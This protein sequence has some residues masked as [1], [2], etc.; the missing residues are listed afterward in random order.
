MSAS[1]IR[2]A[3]SIYTWDLAIGRYDETI[4][5]KGINIKKLAYIRNPY[6]K[7]WF[8]DPFILSENDNIIQLLVE[9]FDSEVNKGRIARIVI[10]K[11]NYTIIECSIIL[12]LETHLSF[13]AIYREG[14][15]IYVHPENSASGKSTIYRYDLEQDRLVDPIVL[16]D[17]P[18]TD[19]VIIQ[20]DNLYIMYST[21]LPHNSGPLLHVYQS[22]SLTHPFCEIK[23]IDYGN[24]T[25]RMAGAILETSRSNI[26][27]AQDCTH[28][29]GEAVLFYDG[30]E[31]VGEIRP[32]A[33][34][35]YAGVH[36]FNKLS[37]TFVIDL[38]KYKYYYIRN[39]IQ[40]I[41]RLFR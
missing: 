40:R 26:R 18:L 22:N 14:E 27:P 30:L 10:S 24:K 3:L 32:K 2:E 21:E 20:K 41:L 37:D 13:P 11:K 23:T 1:F 4:I 17:K 39:F 5:A 33:N 31:L 7:K 12:E 36:T 19:A 9:E 34:G 16:V 15:V 25:A 38:K 6:K 29:Y 28:D 8:A 35:K